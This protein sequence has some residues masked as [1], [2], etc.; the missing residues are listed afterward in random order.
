MLSTPET[1]LA[2]VFRRTLAMY[3]P[4]QPAGSLTPGAHLNSW[5][6]GP[7]IALYALHRTYPQVDAALQKEYFDFFKTWFAYNLDTRPPTPAIN[8]AILINVLWSGLHDPA[9]SLAPMERSVYRAYCLERVEYYR[10]HAI[11]LPSGVFAH[12]VATGSPQS[13]SQVWSDN[14]FMLVL[15]LGRVAV[16]LGDQA[17]FGQM[18]DQLELHYKHLTDPATGLLYH[19]WQATGAPEGRHLNG[20]LWGRGNGW[21][22]LGAAELLELAA[23]PAFSGYQER[24]RQAS[25]PHWTALQRYQRPSGQWNTLIDQPESYPETS[26]T[27]AI[28]A[29]FLKGVRLGALPPEFAGAGQKGLAATLANISDTGDVLGVSGST[30]LL[31]RLADYNAIPNDQVNTWGQGLALLALAEG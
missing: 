19:G 14:L 26:A 22:A 28:S 24:M 3:Q 11:K 6:W 13:K 29:A 21:A 23:A 27:A 8:S 12:T 30:P 2:A 9:I 31:D 18:V 1:K 20:A 10:Q 15:L 25:L 5:D 16:S 7:G 17:L 4:G